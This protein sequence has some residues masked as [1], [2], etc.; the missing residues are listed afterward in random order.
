MLTL[1]QS[2]SQNLS[3]TWWTTFEIGVVQLH[4]V[5]EIAPKS[6]LLGSVSNDDGDGNENAKKAMGLLSRTTNLYVHQA[7][8]RVLS[9]FMLFFFDRYFWNN[10]LVFCI[11]D[12][13]LVL[14]KM[15]ERA[16]SYLGVSYFVSQWSYH[17]MIALAKTTEHVTLILI[18]TPVNVYQVL[19][20]N[21]VKVP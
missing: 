13:L 8:P 11:S 5:T 18:T 21:S 19:W 3:D 16:I 14:R 17:V 15:Q 9:D 7:S 20:G 6:P 4:S 1:H 2:V 12:L 10:D